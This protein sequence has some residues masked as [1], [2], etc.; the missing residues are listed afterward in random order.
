MEVAA[1]PT[2]LERFNSWWA[3]PF[4]SGGSAFSWVLFVGLIIIAVFLWQLIL[5]ELTREVI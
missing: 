1:K 3:A 2:L 5:I 4:Q